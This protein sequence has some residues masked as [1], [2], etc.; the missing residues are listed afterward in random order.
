MISSE[1][2]K[3]NKPVLIPFAI[4]LIFLM[5]VNLAALFWFENR[6]INEES[7]DD[8]NDF[9]SLFKEV[10]DSEEKLLNTLLD[11]YEQDKSL[12]RAYLA[13]DREKLLRKATPY[14]EEAQIL[15]GI[16]HF[17]FIKPDKRVFLRVHRSAQYDDYIEH[18]TLKEA[19]R[20][21]T[22]S[23]DIEL[24]KFG[25]FTLRVVR[26]WRVDG[27]VIGY[28][29]LGKDMEHIIPKLKQITANDLFFWVDKS[30]IKREYWRKGLE[31]KGRSGNWDELAQWV[32]VDRTLRE[33]PEKVREYVQSDYKGQDGSLFTMSLYGRSYRVGLIP[34]KNFGGIE[35]GEIAVMHDV[36]DEVKS[37]MA[38][39]IFVGVSCLIGG[40]IIVYFSY[41]YLRWLEKRLI[42]KHN[43]MSIEL[44]KVS[45][46][47]ELILN[48][49]SEGIFGIDRKGRHTFVNPAA[50]KMLGHNREDLIGKYSH[51]LWHHTKHDGTD[52]QEEECPIYTTLKNG[53]SHYVEDDVFWRKDGTS[54][55]VDYSSTPI[56]AHGIIF[57][58]VVSF[59][60][61]SETKKI[62]EELH[63]SEEVSKT[64]TDAALNAIIMMESDGGITFWNPA[65]E[66][67]FGYMK[68]EALGKDLHFL[69]APN[70]F[71]DDFRKG[72]EELKQSSRGFA[73]GKVMELRGVKKGGETFPLE[74]SLS[75]FETN[76]SWNA[77]GIIRDISERKIAEKERENLQA[78]IRRIQKM[79]AIGTLA[80][81]IAHDFNNILG[82]ILGFTDLA[83]LEVPKEGELRENLEQVRKASQRAKDLVSHIL[84]FSRQ[85][86]TKRR[87]LNVIPIV[88]E[89]IKMLRSTLPSTIEIKQNI[90]ADSF[91]I[92]ADPVQ[93]H[94]ILMSLCTNAADAMPHKTGTLGILMSKT[95][96]S[97][98]EAAVY[99]NISPGE[100]FKLAVSDTGCGMEKTVIERI[101]EPFFTS[102]EKGVGTGM[103]LSVL[104]GIVESY[105]GCI[106]VDSEP[107][108]GST[109]T[110]LIPLIAEE[111]A[112]EESGERAAIPLPK[113]EG[114]VL[115][116]DDD[117]ALVAMGRRM[118]EYLGYEVVSFANSIE[119]LEAF[120]AQPDKFDLVVTD[121]TMPN[122]TGVDLAKKIM[123]IRENMPIII[124]TGFSEIATKDK[125]KAM[126]IRGYLMKPL[127][128][129]ELAVS[130]QDA[131]SSPTNEV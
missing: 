75:S 58:A 69:L 101:F 9:Q 110:V 36:T 67:I 10:L 60:D 77:V 93:I 16:S 35:F 27:E 73:A 100:Y 98:H 63:R 81:G 127:S 62:T 26:P 29:E 122:I 13:K 83:L 125:A 121:Q 99:S 59:R 131:L 94:Q 56:T 4:V 7:R 19:I 23:A 31:D 61:I 130:C 12:Q 5:T 1:I 28:L 96:I 47:T 8:L 53:E 90:T 52:F 79:E 3:I 84:T 74:I 124:C 97:I 87:P 65:A 55:S 15:S 117:T 54:F 49:V 38:L 86:E 22:I 51:S 48:S 17:Y 76:G 104:H 89:A 14:L 118:L 45:Q 57:G 64:I 24:G 119:A 33:L 92:M 128:I 6:R 68:E 18:N 78:Q 66:R 80:G 41:L 46:H 34:L 25:N 85:A 114:T 43:S 105:N 11:N 102:K 109:F 113:G 126:G 111:T 88:K 50:A 123:G 37:F 39:L 82:A 95:E 106:I 70:G 91:K 72:L 71:R 107:G 103:G 30:L 112:G 42:E 40:A 21:N 32:V 115:L 120:Q 116:V 44:S 20:N 108:K 129:S 2:E